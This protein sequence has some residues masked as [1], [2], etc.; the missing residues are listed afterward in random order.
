MD[1]ESQTPS[2]WIKPESE[3]Q[4]KPHATVAAIVVQDN[5]FL[6]VEEPIDGHIILNQPAGHLEDKETL[7]DAVVREVREETA[8]HFTPEYLLGIYLWRHPAKGLTYL[9]AA[10]VGQVSDHDPEQTLLD[11]I[12]RTRWMTANEITVQ[13][14]RLRSPLVLDCVNDYLAGHSYPLDILHAN[15]SMHQ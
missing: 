5:K 2:G 1:S 10:F 6:M 13:A 7:V 3:Q 12:I 14:N 11:G 9:R 4:W 15:Q 8:W